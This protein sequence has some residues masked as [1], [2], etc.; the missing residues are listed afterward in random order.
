MVDRYRAFASLLSDGGDQCLISLRFM[1]DVQ[2]SWRSMHGNIVSFHRNSS[3]RWNFRNLGI[4]WASDEAK[5]VSGTGALPCIERHEYCTSSIKSERD[6]TLIPTI[7]ERL[8]EALYLSTIVLGYVRRQVSPLATVCYECWMTVLNIMLPSD[9]YCTSD[10]RLSGGLQIAIR[11][12][13]D[14][15]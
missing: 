10:G 4:R 3:E 1:L 2:Y 9:E 6:Q 5:M 15:C 7:D 13:L 11:W 12:A 8:V 14:D